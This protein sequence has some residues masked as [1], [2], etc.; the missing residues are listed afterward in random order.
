MTKFLTNHWKRK[1]KVSI[2]TIGKST[3]LFGRFSL[4]IFEKNIFVQD[5]IFH[6]LPKT[7][8]TGAKSHFLSI[9]S[10]EFDISKYVNFV[11]NEIFK[12]RFFLQNGK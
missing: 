10:H 8:H 9:N 1:L 7:P 3:A 2:M 12:M 5:L 11:K 6:T 4:A